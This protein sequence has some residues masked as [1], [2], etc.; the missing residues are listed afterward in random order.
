V[1]FDY[2]GVLTTALAPAFGARA[3]AD[4]MEPDSLTRALRRWL[5]PDSPVDNPVHRLETGEL[6]HAEFGALLASQLRR[7]DGSEVPAEDLMERL[8]AG[9]RLEPLML[10]QVG[11]LRER[12][13]ATAL[14]GNSWGNSY[15]ME[16][17]RPLRRRRHL[18]QVGVRKPD[19]AIY[20][21]TRS[22]RRPGCAG[23]VRRRPGAQRRGRPCPRHARR[24]ARRPA[25]PPPPS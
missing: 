4:Q 17:L 20:S 25:H 24:A 3:Q 2:A 5:A 22:A 14:L 7:L 18:R 8:L 10:E 16:A 15:P 12:G 1:A 11:S 6:A 13:I 23:R 9:L 19:P 21:H